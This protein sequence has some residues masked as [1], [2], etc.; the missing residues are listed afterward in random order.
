[1]STFFANRLRNKFSAS[2][3]QEFNQGISQHLLD[4]EDKRRTNLFTWRGQFSPQLVE[5]LLLA[6]CPRDA[7]VLDPFCGSGT[8]LYEC[9]Y[10][11]LKAV[12]CELNPAAWILSRIYEF[13][14]LR[15]GDRHRIITS[16]SGK[17]QQQFPQPEL[18]QTLECDRLEVPAFQTRL[19]RIYQEVTPLE[20]AI[21]DALVILLDLDIQQP[22]NIQEINTA[23]F[24]IC[25]WIR[26]FPNSENSLKSHLGDARCL[27]VTTDSIDFILTSPP[28]I[29]VFNYHQN[30][31]NSVEFLNWNLL[32][33]AKS[34]I[35]SNRANRRNRF[36][37]VIQ[38]C[39][40]LTLIF[41]EIKR[42]CKPG[43]RIIFVVGYESTVLGVPFYNAKIISE[44][45]TLGGQF[46]LVLTQQRQFKN[47][48]GKMIREDLLHLVQANTT[49]SAGDWEAGVRQIAKAAL[50]NGLEQVSE[51]NKGAL[52]E[53]IA[54]VPE[55]E[56]S[57][58]YVSQTNPENS[59]IK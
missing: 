30:Y 19:C 43:A 5:N 53:A 34:E 29:N 47:K 44:L 23:F 11:G 51:K 4:I 22:I 38:Y 3:V 26:D 59:F 13:I 42:V 55:I 1:M 20:Q 24:A 39:L 33:I 41:K 40:D 36:F 9:G 7:T 50:K 28:Y 12:G 52:L 37:T 45:A 56:R 16:V 10:L 8:V 18:F 14:N 27:P 46:E 57:P 2:A 6:Y 17:L 31:R 54:K 32:E 15:L 35:G 48:F 49:L 25:Q 21:L 58:L